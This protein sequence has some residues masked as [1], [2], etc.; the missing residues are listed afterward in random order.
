MSRPLTDK[1]LLVFCSPFIFVCYCSPVSSLQLNIELWL[2]ALTQSLL[3]QTFHK[4]NINLNESEV[5]NKSILV[6][7]KTL[8]HLALTSLNITR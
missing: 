8:L 7:R 1:Q 2:S 5:Q 4:V 6:Y 3:Q